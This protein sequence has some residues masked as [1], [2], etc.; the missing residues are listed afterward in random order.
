MDVAVIF[1]QQTGHTP[2]PVSHA[3]ALQILGD[4][5]VKGKVIIFDVTPC[6]V[7]FPQSIKNERMIKMISIHWRILITGAIC[8]SLLSMAGYGRR[9]S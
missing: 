4:V 3:H 5:N 7:S 2:S 8:F 9:R 6:K 1:P